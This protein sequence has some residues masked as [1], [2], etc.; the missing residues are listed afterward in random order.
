MLQKSLAAFVNGDSLTLTRFA[1]G[2]V[3]DGAGSITIKGSF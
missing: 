2:A 3:D 1:T